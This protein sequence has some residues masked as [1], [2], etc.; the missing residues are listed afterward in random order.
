MIPSAEMGG[1]EYWC[2]HRVMKELSI[3]AGALS[4]IMMHGKGQGCFNAKV[5]GGKVWFRARDLMEY[6]AKRDSL[7]Y[8]LR[9]VRNELVF[10]AKHG[11]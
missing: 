5:E 1:Q 11:L 9:S 8:Y 6:R 4:W 7:W 10:R 3:G 2:S